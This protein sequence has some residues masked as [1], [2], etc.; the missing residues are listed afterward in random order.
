MARPLA[1]ATLS[2]RLFGLL[3]VYF[4][5]TARVEPA[6]LV[7]LTL[8]VKCELGVTCF[9][10]NYVD[11]DVSDKGRDYQCGSRTYDGHDGTDI[12]IPSL[13]A[14]HGGVDVLASAAG[15][16][17]GARD[18]VEDVSTRVAGK[19]AIAGKEC[20][21]G[22]V[23]EHG[24]GWRTQYCHMAKG[25]VRVKVA[26]RIE[27]G[28]PIGKVGLSGD[29]EF[30][31]VHFS[32][33][34]RGKA[35]DP[36]AYEA[37]PNSCGGGH[38]MWAASIQDQTRYRAREILNFGFSDL[39]PTMNLIESGDVLKHP[40]RMESD[41]F[42]AYV[43]A[44]GLQE[45]DQQTLALQGPGGTV[46]SENKAPVLDRDKAQYFISTGRKR[47]EVAWKPGTY[48]ATYRVTKN[49]AEV[50]RKTFEIQLG[51]K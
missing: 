9:V 7:V 42:T 39:T 29:T 2:L 30:P 34:Y 48:Q 17:T 31:H 36:F 23:I 38:S 25:S 16:V 14:Q 15:S 40:I 32:V 3:S 27:A 49:G 43:R 47:K 1:F 26:D 50:L 51:A 44:I 28:Q 13:G 35:V 10:Q 37:L 5:F 20:G 4:T 33:R 18:G 22:V 11:H 45:G 41:A 24:N 19:A 12:R 8:P 46:I 21:N 6:E